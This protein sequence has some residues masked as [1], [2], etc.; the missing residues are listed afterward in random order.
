MNCAD[1]TAD[2]SDDVQ[3]IEHVFYQGLTMAEDSVSPKLT[4]AMKRE[5]SFFTEGT[6]PFQ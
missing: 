5:Y 6:L 1:W 4:T 2:V 3:L